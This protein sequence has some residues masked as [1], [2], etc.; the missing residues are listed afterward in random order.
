MGL[1]PLSLFTLL[2]KLFF[3]DKHSRPPYLT[4]HISLFLVTHHPPFRDHGHFE[5]K[6]GPLPFISF[7]SL[8]FIPYLFL[9]LAEKTESTKISSFDFSTIP[10][11]MRR[12]LSLPHEGFGFVGSKTKSPEEAHIPL[13]GF[14]AAPSGIPLS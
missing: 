14:I 12:F 10:W 1:L 11:R 4:L 3:S 6:L 2:L 13:G 8:F 9:S 5:N 7:F